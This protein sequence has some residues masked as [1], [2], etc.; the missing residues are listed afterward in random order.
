[1]SLSLIKKIG[2]F[3]N[4]F[5]Y[6]PIVNKKNDS[7]KDT[8]MWSMQHLP[9][10]A[11]AW[12]SKPTIQYW[13][14]IRE[15]TES[16]LI[17]HFSQKASLSSRSVVG[18][19]GCVGKF[20][21]N[22]AK[23]FCI[24]CDSQESVDTIRNKL[25]P[26]LNSYAIDYIWEFSGTEDDERAHVWIMCDCLDVGLLKVFT[27][28]LLLEAGIDYRKIGLE[29]Y[30]TV[31]S[32]NVIR[33]PG[34]IHLKTNKVNPVLWKNVVS[35]SAEFILDA[36][37]AAKPLTEEFVKANI[38]TKLKESKPVRPW[39]IRNKKFFF[40]SRGLKL[41][42]ANLPPVLKKVASNCQAINQVIDGCKNG[43]LLQDKRGLGHTAGLWLW[44]IANYN[45]AKMGK[46]S[47][48][49]EW[50][51]EFTEDYRLTPYDSHNWDRD[52]TAILES[53]DRYFPS[54]KKWE[55]TFNLC[56][57]CPFKDR[58]GFINPKQLW[59]GSPIKK[60]LLSEMKLISAQDTRTDTFKRVSNKIWQCLEDETS[61]DILLASPQGSGKSFKID[62]LTVSL[63]KKGHRVLISV[64]TGN[65][66]I[67]HKNRIEKDLD[68][69]PTGI[70]AFVV[71]SHK[72][73]FDKLNPGFDCPE[74]GNIQYLYNLGISSSVW[75]GAYCK[76][77]P[78]AK[79]CP[80][81]TQYKK[82]VEDA[83]QVV[84]IQ[85]AHLSC[86][87]TMFSIMQSKYDIMFVDEAFIDNCH[88]RI[89]PRQDE[90]A[91]LETF[92][93]EVS[94]MEK[95]YNWLV[96]GG[97]AKDDKD[98]FTIRASETELENLKFSLDDKRIPWNVP[99]YIRYFNLNLYHDKTQGIQMFY[100][101][102]S[103]KVRVFT[104]ATPPIDY[105]KIVLDNNN[106]EVFGDDE[107]L[108]FRKMNSGNTVTQ[109]LDSSMSKTSLKGSL[110]EFGDYNYE[111]FTEILEFIGELATTKYKG[112]KILIT[113][114]EDGKND[115]FK[116]I[117]ETFLKNNYPD[118]DVGREPPSQVCIGHMMI[119]TNKFED[120]LI[121]F[122]VA[123]VYLNAYMFK[124]EVFRLK[125]I[126]NFWN[127]V[128]DRP[129]DPNPFPSD[130]G[131]NASIPREREP[132]KR[133][134]PIN[135][136]A[137]I[138]EYPDFTYVFP[139]DPDYNIIEKFAI[140]KTQQAIRLRFNDQRKRDIFVFGNYF[141]P[142]FL[143]TN[144]V[145]EDDLL[146][147]LRNKRSVYLDSNLSESATDK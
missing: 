111:R 25:L 65:L 84:I 47:E 86:K 11:R 133:I 87:E 89:K 66:A 141:L 69:N 88:K 75:K 43:S 119:G 123:G 143:I 128:N 81:P 142:S 136:R 3:R 115:K 82:V 134:L 48:G 44:S 113:T 32:G 135:N 52:R 40:N 13:P 23:W 97:Y 73:L 53:P 91:V 45:D 33:L 78:Y 109:V 147:Y 46:K 30:P 79:D 64:P 77:C 5:F 50:I 125:S 96:N 49:E 26:I 101:L 120:Y 67:E 70:K 83:P 85:H 60:Y 29:L 116:T 37:I 80:Y 16:D 39:D 61:K 117:A 10:A 104:D 107:V 42:V 18:S 14:L 19:M 76:K 8:I 41:P 55:E 63:A 121:Q 31:K 110:D 90:L 112:Q 17:K 127:R 22:K 38:K 95:L 12:E 2:E 58:P 139:A 144:S 34:G 21:D 130:I 100:P 132:I 1:M 7:G 71:M 68:G 72:N 27:D 94:W 57:G 9:H 103:V 129:I 105:L 56:E 24:D 36:F 28:Q 20:K 6:G 99:D 51:K 62:E 138:F 124:Q 122:L 54:C 118:L 114:Y 145:L 131:D 74:E 93:K 140:A 126:S 102:P 137:A 35:A 106:I 108:D 98:K 146:G 59:Y 4:K 15:M 92:I